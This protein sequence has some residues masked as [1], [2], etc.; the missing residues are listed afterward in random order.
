MAASRFLRLTLRAVASL[1]AA[2]VLYLI[3]LAVL[4]LYDRSTNLE[5]P[6][7]TGPFAVGRTTFDW[8]NDARTDELAPSSPSHESSAK[9]EMLVWI[10]YPASASPSAQPSGYRPNWWLDA[11][12]KSSGRFGTFLDHDAA[13]IH[14]HS[15]DDPPISPAQPSY[16]VVIFRAG[17]G[18]LTTDYTTLIEDLASH[19]YIVVGFDAPYRTGVVVFP[20]GR[21]IFRPPQ[22]NPDGMPDADAQSFIESLLPMW[23]TDTQFVAD[24]LA[25]LNASD[26]QGR[27]TGRLDLNHLGM[28]G[29]S[30]GGAQTLQFCHDDP[31]CKAGIDVDGN[32][33]GSV[34]REGLAQPF[35]LLL[36]HMNIWLPGDREVLARLQQAYGGLLGSRLY[37]RLRGANHF[38]FSDQILVKPRY[39]VGP[40]LFLTGGFYQRRGLAASSAA[41]HTFFDVYLKGQ[42]ASLFDTLRMDYPELEGR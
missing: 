11:Y 8:V 40:L 3:L 18:A 30:F 17:L 31:R 28:F 15:S 29:H 42:P 16:P 41:I 10:W 25:R 33:F 38:S 13:K 4:I 27:F 39:I 19:G 22:L 2:G 21:A 7:P 5:L 34:V 26:P 32:P 14:V 6:T 37:L 23:I 24:R 9:R 35:M 1:A 36:E 20:D 12:A